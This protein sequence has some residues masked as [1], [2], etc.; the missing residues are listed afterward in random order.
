M[1]RIVFFIMITVIVLFIG[2]ALA[3]AV[4]QP[5]KVLPRI[6]LAPGF[7]LTDQEGKRLTNESLR[8]SIVVYSFMYTRCG[9]DC[10]A[11]LDTLRA[12]QANLASY[13]SG[14]IP[15]QIVT[16][17]VDPVHDTSAAL[18]QFAQANQAEPATWRIGTMQD[19]TLLKTVVGGGFEVFYQ[20]N[21][22]GSIKLDQVFTLVDAY[23]IIRGEY[24]YS[25]L[26][27]NS[28]R[29]MRHINVLVDEIHKSVG[30]ARLAYEAAHLFLCYAP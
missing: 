10:T 24:R 15:V 21:P 7:A 28:E 3:F 5:I 11:S 30:A 23:G 17:S 27:S 1:K 26:T 12:V 2:S 6:R 19:A 25:G 9:Q 22:D 4:I 13:K 8:G 20:S 29:I 14:G 18:L 16:I